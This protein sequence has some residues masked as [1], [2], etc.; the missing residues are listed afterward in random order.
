MK[1]HETTDSVRIDKGLAEKI[2]Q[3]AKLKGQTIA[4]YINV[5]LS[6]QVERDW[7]KYNEKINGLQQG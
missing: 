3:I 2:R 1:Q 6:R 4:G 7:A 5:N